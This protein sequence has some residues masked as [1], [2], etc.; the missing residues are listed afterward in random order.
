LS[1]ITILIFGSVAGCI[2]YAFYCSPVERNVWI[3]LQ[4]ISCFGTFLLSMTDWFNDEKNVTVKGLTYAA[5][6]IFAGVTCINLAIN[7]Q[8]AGPDS[9]SVPF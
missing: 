6:G 7:S 9:D 4:F 2:Y 8:N 1:G 3:L 5:C